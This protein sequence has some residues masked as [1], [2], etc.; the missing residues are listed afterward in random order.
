MFRVMK[1]V[2][3]NSISGKEK[4]STKWAGNKANLPY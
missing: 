4:K 2:G 3:N 1:R